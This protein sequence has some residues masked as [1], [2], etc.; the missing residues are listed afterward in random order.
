MQQIKLA[1]IEHKGNHRLLVQFPYDS[2]II[3]ILKNIKGTQWSRTHKS[4][5]IDKTPENLK[6]IYKLFE[7]VAVIDDTLVCNPLSADS[8]KEKEVIANQSTDGVTPSHPVSLHIQIPNSKFQIP[9]FKFQIPRN[10]RFKI[11]SKKKKKVNGKEK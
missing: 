7:G 10:S 9:R 8:N 1:P 4:W 2:K 6:S 3:S 5:H 11:N